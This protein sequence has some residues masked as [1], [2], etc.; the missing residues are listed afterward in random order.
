MAVI[1]HEA[2]SPSATRRAMSFADACFDGFATVSG[3]S[4]RRV[5]DVD[6]A[7]TLL[8]VRKALPLLIG[9]IEP[10]VSALRPE[11]LVDA[12][13][14]KRIQPEPQRTLAALTV[15]LGPNFVAGQTTELVVETSWGPELGRVIERGTAAPLAGEPRAI[16]GHARD[17]FVYAPVDGV[18]RTERRIGQLVRRGEVL[19]TIDG[20]SIGAPLDGA[21]RGL[22]HDGVNVAAGTK[23]VEVDPRGS[24]ATVDGIGERPALIADGVLLSI[25]RWVDQR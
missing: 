22:T 15:G 18:F 19:A 6:A 21:L 1:L 3:L 2:G 9:E 17:R 23:V 7:R 14:R 16:A 8:S 4:A 12:R 10:V 24:Q 5:A 25:K 20:T 11:V 13:M